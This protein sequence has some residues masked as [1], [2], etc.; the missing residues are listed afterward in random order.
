MDGW[1]DGWMDE[2]MD[3]VHFRRKGLESNKFYENRRSGFVD[4]IICIFHNGCLWRP[5]FC[6]ACHVTKIKKC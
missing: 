4:M 5:P 6:K 3:G 1:M 2:W